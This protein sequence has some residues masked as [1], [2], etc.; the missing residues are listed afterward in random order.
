MPA[1]SSTDFNCASS[2][3][4][5]L[6]SISSF[7]NFSLV[8]FRRS[9]SPRV[10]PSWVTSEKKFPTGRKIVAATDWTGDSADCEP[11]RSP[12]ITCTPR[13]S[14]VIR[15][16]AV[17]ISEM[18]RRRPRLSPP[19]RICKTYRRGSEI[20][21]FSRASNSSMHFPEPSTTASNGRSAI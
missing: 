8:A 17:T 12:V 15:N 6:R 3:S 16:S 4:A 11:L 2:A 9:I 1:R 20:K 21:T 18:R 5:F 10:R 13:R 19:L 7:C 14:K